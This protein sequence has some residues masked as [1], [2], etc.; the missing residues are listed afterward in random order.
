MKKVMYVPLAAAALLLCG[1]LPSY[2]AR[3]FQGRVGVQG[4]AEVRD[5][6]G[7]REQHEFH[8]HP[9]VHDRHQFVDHRGFRRH[10]GTEVFV[11][12]G[13]WW[14]PD[15]WGP[16]YSPY[17]QPPAYIPPETQP[18]YYWYYCF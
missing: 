17:G 4:H 1:T 6:G 15:W 14:P 16:E 5:H 9:R 18:Q 10:H 3:S 2:A 12:P 11:A 13:F 8:S 7:P